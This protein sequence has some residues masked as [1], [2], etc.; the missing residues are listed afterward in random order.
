MT[1]A[2][3]TRPA[4]LS[5]L[6][7]LMQ[8]AGITPEELAQ[9]DDSAPALRMHVPT[10]PRR[11]RA[12]ND[13]ERRVIE[14]AGSPHGV[15][16]DGVRQLLGL[17]DAQA[18]RYCATLAEAGHLTGVKKPGVRAMRF[19]ATAE[20]A[21]AWADSDDGTAQPPV[22]CVEPKPGRVL[23]SEAERKTLETNAKKRAAAHK[24]RPP[25]GART[26]AMPA[27]VEIKPGKVGAL[28][29]GQPIV[30][31]ATRRSID[32]TPRPNSRIEAAPALPPDPRFPS[33]SSEWKRLRGEATA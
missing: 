25:M 23:L 3:V 9:Q 5:V 2:T 8:A 29:A 15:S 16:V 32:T 26:T 24:A 14:A 20:A 21:R 1:A 6:R 30:T 4:L 18:H 19:F 7:Y 27:P 22:P 11:A 17:R 31:E 28:A 10:L 12:L 33:F 13:N